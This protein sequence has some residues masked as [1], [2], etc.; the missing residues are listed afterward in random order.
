M[1]EA[2]FNIDQ[3]KSFFY[4]DIVY[5][6][7]A[8]HYT[9]TAT[10]KPALQPDPTGYTGSVLTDL[11]AAVDPTYKIWGIPY[12]G[13]ICLDFGYNT[14]DILLT[15]KSAVN[16]RDCYKNLLYTLFDY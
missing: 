15:L 3:F 8:I 13:K 11:G 5:Y 12:P 1:G 10:A 9:Y 4:F 16:W 7:K 6:Q 14:E 2:Q